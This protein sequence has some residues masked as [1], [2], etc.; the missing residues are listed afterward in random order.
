LN[1]STIKKAAYSL[2]TGLL[3]NSTGL[4]TIGPFLNMS[5]EYLLSRFHTNARAT[6]ILMRH[7]GEKMAD[8]AEWRPLGNECHVWPVQS[9]KKSMKGGYAGF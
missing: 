8:G 1:K 7:F 3:V 6:L 9:K 2:E 4:S 5:A